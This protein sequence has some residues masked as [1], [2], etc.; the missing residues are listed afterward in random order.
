MEQVMSTLKARFAYGIV[1]IWLM[2]FIL[3]YA[4]SLPCIQ[5]LNTRK[6]I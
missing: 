2:M 4:L 5:L 3:R 6:R 1:C